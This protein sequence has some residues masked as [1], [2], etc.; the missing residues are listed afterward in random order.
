MHKTLLF[1]SLAVIISNSGCSSKDTAAPVNKNVLNIANMSSYISD[2]RVKGSTC[3]AP[4]KPV[5][6]SSTLAT[7]AKSHVK[8]IAEMGKM[9]HNGSGSM[10]DP[11]RPSINVGSTFVD[12]MKY[13]GYG[14]KVGQLVGENLAKTSIKLTKSDKPMP[15]FKRAIANLMKDRVHCE[16]I[17]NPRFNEIGMAIHRKGDHYYFVME[18]GERIQSKIKPY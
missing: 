16:S 13:F 7:I 6:W 17:M 11:A 18:L 12:R 8:D 3:A 10:L 9:T 15:N 5:R 4:A 2:I 14:T 1:L